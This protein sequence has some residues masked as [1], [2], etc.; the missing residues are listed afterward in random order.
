MRNRYY[1]RH[2]S[3]LASAGFTEPKGAFAHNRN[4]VRV[5]PRP[6]D[7]DLVS[8]SPQHQALTELGLPVLAIVQPAM[9]DLDLVATCDPQI[10]S[11]GPAHEADE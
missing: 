7:F 3:A 6:Q 9:T 4:P 8:G 11:M 2:H 10:I 1:G 5:Q